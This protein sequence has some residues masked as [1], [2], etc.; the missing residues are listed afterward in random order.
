MD[1]YDVDSDRDPDDTD[2]AMV[3]EAL[4]RVGRTRIFAEHV[5]HV[6]ETT[7][8]TLSEVRRFA[9]EA[10]YVVADDREAGGVEPF[11]A[12]RLPPID[13][14]PVRD[15]ALRTLAVAVN[16]AVY[17]SD[18]LDALVEGVRWLRTRP[19]VAAVLLGGSA[20]SEPGETHT[21]PRK[22]RFKGDIMSAPHDEPQF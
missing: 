22:H 4:V 10:G 13:P 2:R 7:G 12:K 3:V 5:D 8:H 6:A 1:A 19:D 14:D 21:G 20:G 16:G 11:E 9:R 17:P 15:E 18:R